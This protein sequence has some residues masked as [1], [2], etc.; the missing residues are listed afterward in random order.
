MRKLLFLGFA[1]LVALSG[2]HRPKGAMHPTQPIAHGQPPPRQVPP[3]PLAGEPPRRYSRSVPFDPAWMP[4]GGKISS[5]WTTVVI[6][7]SATPRGS[8]RA[9]DKA[10]RDKGWDELG[11]H[12]VIGNGTGSGDGQIEVGPRWYKQKHGAHC[13]TP[14]NYFNEHGIGICLVGDFTKSRPTPRQIASLE[15]LTTFLCERCGIP[16]SRVVTHGGVTH[17]TQCPGY[18]FPL[19]AVRRAVASGALATS[20]Q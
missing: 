10:H 12:F 3:P 15:R 20:M 9:F 11:Y 18:N 8:A 7:H 19:A 13:K 2:C 5:R 6:H 17:K 4:P 14:D 1:G 16:P